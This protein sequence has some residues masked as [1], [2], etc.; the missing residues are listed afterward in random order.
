MRN[1]LKFLNLSQLKRDKYIEKGGNRNYEA[2]GSQVTESKISEDNLRGVKKVKG[3][4]VMATEEESL[5][6]HIY[7]SWI[8]G[9]SGDLVGEEDG[10]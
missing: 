10:R 4:T 9:E 5:S 7:V 8:I 1:H 6:L 3:A 2:L